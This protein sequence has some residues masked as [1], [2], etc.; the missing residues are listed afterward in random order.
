M[1]QTILLVDD[2]QMVIQCTL[3]VLGLIDGIKVVTAKNGV[4]AVGLVE[5]GLI[6]DL[7]LT[8]WQMTLMGGEALVTELRSRGCCQPFILMTGDARVPKTIPGVDLVI[9]KPY[10]VSELIDAVRDR[11]DARAAVA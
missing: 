10:D 7:L 11:M 2:D 4:E 5:G 9:L 6:F 1:A 8:D 3:D